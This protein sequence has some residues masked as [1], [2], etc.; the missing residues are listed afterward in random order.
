MRDDH[1]KKCL[2]DRII[3]DTSNA[4]SPGLVVT[5]AYLLSKDYEYLTQT[6]EVVIRVA[7]IHLM[8]RRLARLT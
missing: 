7:M 6:S 8:V 2:D 5:A 3:V 4:P 1:D